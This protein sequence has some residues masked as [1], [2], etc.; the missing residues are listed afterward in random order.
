M[1]SLE[2][3]GKQGKRFVAHNGPENSSLSDEER[4]EHI[5]TAAYFKAS[6]RQFD[7]GQELDDWLEAE[8]EFNARTQEGPCRANE[9]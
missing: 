4:L 9:A 2:S 3:K 1:K 7:A 6:S 8:A 5:R